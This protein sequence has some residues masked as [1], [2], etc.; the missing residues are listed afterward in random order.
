MKKILFSLLVPALFMGLMTSCETDRDSN[1]TLDV[2][3]AQEGF[4]LNVPAN[5]V[6]NTYDL[7]AGESITRFDRNKKKKKS[8][9]RKPQQDGAKV[10]ENHSKKGENKSMKDEERQPHGSQQKEI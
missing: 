10:R 8:K 2:S 1:P 3:K 5:A 4:H 7:L 6:N 9:S